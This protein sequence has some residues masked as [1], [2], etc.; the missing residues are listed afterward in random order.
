MQ[1]DHVAVLKSLAE[2]SRPNGERCIHFAT[3]MGATNLDRQRVRFICRHFARKGLAEFH[4][5]LWTDDGKPAGSGYC[6]THAGLHALPA[7]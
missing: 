5:A 3:I 7:N 4:N 2:D 6:I 1:P